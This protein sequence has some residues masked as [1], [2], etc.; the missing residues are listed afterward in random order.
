MSNQ[1]V[2]LTVGAAGSGKST[3]AKHF[4]KDNH[5]FVN[6]NRDDFRAMVYAL[7]KPQDYKF[8][9]DRER[10]ITE[11]QFASAVA[12]LNSGKSLVISD[13]NL[14]AA[15]RQMWRDIAIEHGVEYFETSFP[16]DL[17][18]LRKR[19]HERGAKA[20]PTEHLIRQYHLMREYMGEYKYEPNEDLPKAVIYDL[21]GTLADN[22]HRSPY[23]F[24]R[25]SEDKPRH[26][27]IEHLQMM[28]DAGYKI[29]T[30]SGREKGENN[31]FEEAT[32]DW[33]YKHDIYPNAHF[34]RAHADSRPD[35]IV[36]EEIFKNHIA[37]YY[38][39]KLAVDDREQVVDMYRAIGVECWQVNYGYF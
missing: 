23:D 21:D 25:I 9:K 29:I 4:I 34:Q 32:L 14:N 16:V 27:V 11:A 33:L 17:R 22:N 10:K 18:E 7:D 13:T 28:Q 2:I 8:T 36:K 3:W 6:L 20:I 37:P 35:S 31:E 15:T 30:C 1:Q 26:M 39:V 38:N 19:N 12:L 5:N 24:T